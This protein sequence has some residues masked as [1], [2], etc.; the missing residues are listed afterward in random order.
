MGV[1]RNGSWWKL[2]MGGLLALSLL[3]SVGFLLLPKL[4]YRWLGGEKFRQ[5]ASTQL[6]SVLKTEGEL[7]PLSWNSFTVESDGFS[8]RSDAAGPWLWKIDKVRTGIS[9]MLLLDRILR[10]P[11][12]TVGEVNL[13]PG[14]KPNSLPP[15]VQPTEAKPAEKK[16]SADLLKEVQIGKIMV[17]RFSLAPCAQTEGWGVRGIQAV[18]QPG[19]KG[20]EF[21]L[22]GG[23]ILCPIEE[24]GIVSLEQMQ[25]RYTDPQITLSRFSARSK[26]GGKITASGQ[27]ILGK[28]PQGQGQ[29]N[30]ENWEIPGGKIGVGLFEIPAKMSGE[31]QLQ[32][33]QPG[34]PVGQG[35]ARLVGARLEPGQGSQTILGLLGLLAGDTRLQRSNP[36]SKAQAQFSVQPG[37]YDVKRIEAE[38]PGVLRVVGQVRVTGNNLAGQLQLGLEQ[39]LGAK[40]NNLTGGECFRR[41]ENGYLY[42]PV[43]LAGTME[44][45]QNDLEPKLKAALKRTAVR[46]TVD[47]IQKATG[48]TDPNT[49]AGAAGQI[50]KSFFGPAPK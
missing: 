27:F 10:F 30:W 45:P 47:I 41:E 49:P 22:K 15:A 42:E 16:S 38:V 31:F 23:E 20:T 34:G 32:E 6:S 35:A 19:V 46:T 8:S 24:L 21:N 44:R 48:N 2:F 7:A 28:N 43:N 12:I 1:K 11:E 33:V 36:L 29:F 39:G 14:L 26:G 4:V 40:V 50:L 17:G 18:I 3:V 37:M 5:L 9:P 25:G 13:A